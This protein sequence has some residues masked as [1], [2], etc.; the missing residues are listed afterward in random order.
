[1]GRFIKKGGII[2]AHPPCSREFLSYP[3]VSFCM[4]PD[5]ELKLFSTYEK[6][7]SQPFKSVAC[8]F[9]QKSLSYEQI[10]SLCRQLT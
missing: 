5:G 4:E 3:S 7:L 9:P 8:S 2:E 10:M 6:I 1:M